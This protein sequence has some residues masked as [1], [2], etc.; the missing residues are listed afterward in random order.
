ME[1][2]FY[3]EKSAA[4]YAHLFDL[5]C[6]M[7]QNALQEEQLHE[8]EAEILKHQM[9][10]LD[11]KAPSPEQMQEEVQNLE[12]MQKEEPGPE[13]M[14]RKIQNL[15]PMQEENVQCLKTEGSEPKAETQVHE[16]QKNDRG[17]NKTTSVKRHQ[18]NASKKKNRKKNKSH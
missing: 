10:N 5:L 7:R 11:S 6:Q 13:Q 2:D 17:S 15:G 14:Q 1:A 16:A 3:W 4:E 9:Q 8:Q 18:Y 12:A